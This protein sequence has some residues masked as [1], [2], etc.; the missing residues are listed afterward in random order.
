MTHLPTLRYPRNTNVVD[1]GDRVQHQGRG[2]GQGYLL[3]LGPDLDLHRREI[4]A[5]GTMFRV[6]DR[7]HGAEQRKE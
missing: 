3:G 5:D 4:Q 2:R 1:D 7:F 6:H